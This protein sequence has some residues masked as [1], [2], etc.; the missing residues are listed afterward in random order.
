MKENSVLKK[1][2]IM[3]SAVIEELD[4]AVSKFKVHNSV[5]YVQS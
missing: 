1:R 3:K 5:K 2:K 4:N